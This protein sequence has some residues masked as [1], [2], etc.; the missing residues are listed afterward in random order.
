MRI[1]FFHTAATSTRLQDEGKFSVP[2]DFYRNCRSLLSLPFP[3]PQ[4][5]VFWLKGQLTALNKYFFLSNSL[6]YQSLLKGEVS[7]DMQ[8]PSQ[9]LHFTI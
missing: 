6:V 4:I 9:L 3:Q 1:N 2:L 8:Y 5:S 7:D